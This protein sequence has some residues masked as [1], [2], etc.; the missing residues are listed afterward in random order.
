MIM[1]GP[2]WSSEST[3]S[4]DSLLRSSKHLLILRQSI[5][6]KHHQV[7]IQLSGGKAELISNSNLFNPK[8]FRLGVFESEISDNTAAPL[9]WLQTQLDAMGVRQRR[10]KV[11]GGEM[12]EQLALRQTV[13]PHEY[14][15][16]LN[17]R[18]ID[19]SSTNYTSLTAS[20]QRLLSWDG[21]NCRHCIVG[22]VKLK[23]KDTKLKKENA[24]VFVQWNE[25]KAKKSKVLREDNCQLSGR[26][27]YLCETALGY[28]LLRE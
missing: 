20:L 21:W 11:D 6:G 22:Q 5:Y 3:P 19:A 7:S 10:I 8:V 27:T 2:A 4:V 12:T 17:G 15:L 28:L 18:Q 13:H 23:Q 14:Q 16:L 24:K 9:R 1:A 26:Q 25:K